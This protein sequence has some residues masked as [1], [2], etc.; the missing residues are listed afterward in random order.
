MYHLLYTI[1]VT[2][3]NEGDGGRRGGGLS[4]Q[5]VLVSRHVTRQN[6]HL[7]ETC[8]ST[9]LTVCLHTSRLQAAVTRALQLGG[10]DRGV[11]HT[12]THDADKLPLPPLPDLQVSS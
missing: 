11:R 5:Q 2:I 9:C 6:L 7:F 4:W 1:H 3:G 10:G 12:P 8:V